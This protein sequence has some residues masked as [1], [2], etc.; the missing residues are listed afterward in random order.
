MQETFIDNTKYNFPLEN[1]RK[2]TNMAKMRKQS[3]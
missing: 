1:H 3:R 2:K